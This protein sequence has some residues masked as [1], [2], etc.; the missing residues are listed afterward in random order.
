[1]I[2]HA[3]ICILAAALLLLAGTGPAFAKADQS[4]GI[5]PFTLYA[6]QPDSLLGKKIPLMIAQKL[7]DEGA[8]TVFFKEET[9]TGLLTD[10]AILALGKKAGT[11]Y[12]LSGSVFVSGTSFSIDTTLLT[13][14]KPHAPAAFSAEAPDFDNLLSAVNRITREIISKIFKKQII[15]TI[16]VTG[17]KRVETDAIL[18]IIDSKT[19]DIFKEEKLSEDLGKIH[20]MGYFEAVTVK[21]EEL[22]TGINIVFDVTEK[23]SVRRISYTNN[24]VFKDDELSEAVHT[25]TGSILNLVKLKEDISRLK[26]MYT[27]KNYHNCE[28]SYEIISLDNNQADIK[29]IVDEG[30][31]LRIQNITFEGNQHFS[32]KKL[33]KEM[34]TSE[35]GF[36]S[37]FTSSGDLD[38]IELN[39][40]VI[41]LESFYKNNGYA[42]AKVSDPDIVFNEDGIDVSF[43]I[44]E[45]TQYRIGTID[46]KGDLIIPEEEIYRKLTIEENEVYN[47]ETIRK[48]VITLTDIY[49]DQG[50]ANAD[51]KPATR[52]SDDNRID[53][54]F[55]ISKGSPVY[56][57]RV[58]ISGNLKT[59]DKVIRREIKAREQSLFSKSSIQQSF[60]NLTRL[61]YFQEIDIKPT[62][63]SAPD[64]VNLNV[65]IV[66]KNTGSFSFGGG[67]S[68]QDGAFLLGTVVEKNLFGKGQLAKAKVEISKDSNRISLGFTEPWL[69]DIPLSAGFE[70]YKWD[71]EFRYYDK[72]ALGIILKSGYKLSDNTSVGLSVN[73]EE[74]DIENNQTRYTSVT[75][76]NFFHGSITP[77][78]KYDS[79]DRLFLPTEGSVHMLSVEYA[80]EYL[81]GDI[82]YI[83]YVG[84]TGWYF[85][86]FWK[87][88]GFVHGEIGLLD[89]RTKGDIDI[90]YQRF[91]LGGMNSIRGFDYRD[92]NTTEPGDDIHRGGEKYLQFNVEVTFPLYEEQAIA[93]VVF[94]D[95]GD[96]YT[97][98]DSFS[99]DDQFSSY[100]AGVR[101][102]SPLGP[103]R[104]E[105]GIVIDGKDKRE[106]G[107]GKW[108]FSFGAYF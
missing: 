12:M 39:N 82:D 89:D 26:R 93:G 47:R 11:D 108:E 99:F 92:I 76:G 4:V 25:R 18:N 24:H 56:F 37:F 55:E 38:E 34:E 91:Y 46:V 103:L 61:D 50:F 29:F 63:A 72:N 1:M 28:I 80:G 65:D 40:D 49:A 17:N 44:E 15:T 23:P 77:S 13:T 27:D 70:I 106:S 14:E 33:K 79:R 100:G 102:N 41:R 36:F 21:K 104:I 101:W 107:K 3:L 31:K 58:I 105:Y 88:T 52:K 60:K 84:E 8:K 86:L 66:E 5:L 98:S 53:I 83:K 57:E 71:Y 35:K 94:Y 32:D 78:I 87:F 69:F 2:K 10:D 9:D 96:V 54:S 74:F 45:G 68:D 6:D 90:D 51:I 62:R 73:W 43:K 30:S 67:Y 97:D 85:P 75:P 48:D 7:E 19:G 42:D 59:R 20:K 81:G 64:R 16:S 22:D 95:R